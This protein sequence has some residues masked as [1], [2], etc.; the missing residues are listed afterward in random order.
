MHRQNHQNNITNRSD[1]NLP[2]HIFYRGSLKSCQYSCSY[3][4]FA[5]K[6]DSKATLQKDKEKLERFAEWVTNYKQPVNILFT[7]YGEALIRSYYR[8]TL[9]RLAQ[10]PHVVQVAIQTNLH[11]PLEWLENAPEN[12]IAL[13]CSYHPT[14]TTQNIFLARCNQLQSI[15]VS[16]SVGIVAMRENFKHIRVMRQA[17]SP[18][19]YLWLNANND[20]GPHY[21]QPEEIDWLQSIDP[22][23]GYSVT[24][25]ASLGCA[26]YAGEKSIAVDS[27]G[28]ITRCQFL[29]KK[30]GNLY[31]DPLE[32]LLK[33]KHCTR[34]MCDCYIGYAMRKDRPFLD[35]FGE[36]ILA[37][38]P[39]PAFIQNKAWANTEPLSFKK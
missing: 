8:E 2:L 20:V 19:I 23:F 31:T 30:L 22:W 24:H 10:L 1:D 4:P 9:I 21:Y 5:K 37:R 39:L 14:Q 18:E 11:I 3:C 32:N 29:R 33:Q 28:N 25:R 15:N 17:L 34:Q 16:F 6:K 35:Q 27:E 13:W 36:G 38:I 7:P 12:K 26:C